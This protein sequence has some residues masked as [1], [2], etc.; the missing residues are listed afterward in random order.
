MDEFTELKKGLV[1]M[2]L[3][4]M[5]FSF[6]ETANHVSLNELGRCLLVYYI[7]ILAYLLNVRVT[8]KWIVYFQALLVFLFAGFLSAVLM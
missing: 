6:F 7:A 3:F 1:F 4:D 8:S 2:T 5:L